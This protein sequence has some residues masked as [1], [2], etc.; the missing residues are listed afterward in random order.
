MIDATARRAISTESTVLRSLPPY[1]FATLERR[2]EE[3]RRAGAALHPFHIGDPDLPPPPSVV[4]AA[5]RAAQDPQNCR[6]SSSRGEPELREAIG[7][8]M[9]VRFGVHVDPDTEVAVLIG[10]KE[11]LALLPRALAD[12]GDLVGV[13][14]PG[15]PA[16]RAAATLSGARIGVVP[17]DPTDHWRP[18]WD[19]LEGA[20]RL[21]YLNYP[22]NPTGA[23]IDLVALTEAV[24]RARDGGWTLAFD[25][26]YSELTYG[27]TGAPSILE[28]PGGR[29][30]GVEFHSFSKTFGV[31]GWR[32]GFAVGNASAIAALVKLKGQSDSG[33]ALP[34][35]R[36]A[37]A[38][39]ALYR[40]RER[41]PEVERPVREYG[42]RL[43]RLSQALGAHGVEAP[44]PDG[45]L[46]L[47]HRAPRGSG[48]AFADALLDATGILVT[49]GR[50]F[51]PA[52]EG[53][54]RWA[55]TRP[56][57]EIEEVD[58]LLSRAPELFR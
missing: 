47:W 20:P 6:Y 11:G 15:Y 5:A 50:A 46:Y 1:P 40:G 21:V 58:G 41:P 32:I 22:N 17:L 27:P 34:L 13:P 8:W 28:V 43:A 51:G 57:A 23:A 48:S 53:Y 52:G 2:A 35:Q 33:A 37:E 7:R 56:I 30:V 12:A 3:R 44:V 10:S 42:R 19:R 16:Y 36:A 25:N 38:A 31:P 54:V 55:V 45:G 49:P 26:A 9:R 29:E 39:L 4:E 24:D 14:D 18:V